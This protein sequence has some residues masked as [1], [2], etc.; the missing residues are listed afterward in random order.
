[1]IIVKRR[2]FDLPNKGAICLRFELKGRPFC[3]IASH[4]TSD[5]EKTIRCRN[6]FHS[7]MRESFFDKLSQSCIPANRH[8]Y[9]FFMGDLNLGMWMEM[10]RIYIERGLLCGKLERL[11]TFD[12]LN[13]ERYY[14]RSFDEFEEMR[15]TWGATYMF[16]VGSHVFDTRYEQ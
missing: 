8:D 12:Q 11:L 2:K 16:N 3:I 10:Q 6:D 13:M 9:C 4:L 15:V 14:K 7:M 1:M 5:Q